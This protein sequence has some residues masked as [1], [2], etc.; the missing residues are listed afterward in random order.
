MDNEDAAYDP[1]SSSHVW[2]QTADHDG[3]GT[4]E[5]ALFAPLELDS[6]FRRVDWRKRV[7]LVLTVCSRF[8][9]I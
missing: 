4:F 9:E 6:R 8:C 1:F 7:A 2:N 3:L 5:S